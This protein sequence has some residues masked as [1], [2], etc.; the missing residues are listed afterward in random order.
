MDYYEPVELISKDHYLK[1]LRSIVRRIAAKGN[2]VIHGHGAHMLVPEAAR[3]VSVFVAA[4]KQ[5]RLASLARDEGL[6]GDEAVKAL[7]RADRDTLSACRY[8][9]DADFEN[10]GL[11]DLSINPERVPIT[12]A[13]QTVA[14]A[15]GISIDDTVLVPEG[16]AAALA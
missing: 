2:A 10:S 15:L 6:T 13:A 14:G 8:L 12:M 16:E 11:Y 5:W 3:S 9:F 4:S 7:K 1:A